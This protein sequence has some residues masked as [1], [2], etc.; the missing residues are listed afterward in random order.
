MKEDHEARIKAL[1]TTV[2]ELSYLVKVQSGVIKNLEHR[3]NALK[4]VKRLRTHL[5]QVN[6]QS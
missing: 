5:W 3:V 2:T 1:E 6:R 4:P